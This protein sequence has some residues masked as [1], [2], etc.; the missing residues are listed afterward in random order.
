MMLSGASHVPHLDEG[1]ED[2]RQEH[3]GAHEVQ[4]VRERKGR[5]I[6]H[7]SKA[8]RAPRIGHPPRAAPTQKHQ[9]DVQQPGVQ[10][11]RD[12]DDQ[13]RNEPGRP[14]T[15]PAQI[16]VEVHHHP[17]NVDRTTTVF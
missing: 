15:A 8:A 2:H 9:K 14:P 3:A 13:R 7:F 17:A 5:F 16:C 1:D 4:P 11:D 12:E 6:G 10:H